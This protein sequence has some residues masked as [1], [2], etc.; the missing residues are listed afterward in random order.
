[1]RQIITFLAVAAQI[2]ILYHLYNLEVNPL[3]GKPFSNQTVQRSRRNSES[4]SDHV[5]FNNSSKKRVISLQAGETFD[6]SGEYRIIR[7]YKNL[8]IQG[9]YANMS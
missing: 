3:T 4:A 7:F 5:T 2:T 8:G 6:Y 9:G 1:M